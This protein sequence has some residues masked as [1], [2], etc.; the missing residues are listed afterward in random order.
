M[1]KRTSNDATGAADREIAATRIFDAPR[2]L[3]FQMWTDPKHIAQWWGPRGFT[4]TTHEMNFKP[5]G[6]WRFVMHGPDGTDYQNK[7]IYEE[8]VEPE[9]LVYSHVSGPQFHVTVNF[10][11][12]DSGKT[13]LTMR[14]LFESAAERS[15]VAKEH[16]AVEGLGQ[17]LDRLGEQLATFVGQE[18]VFTRVFDAPREL[19]WKAFVESER[20]MHWWGP[21]GF[22]MHFAKVDLRPGGIFHYGMQSPDGKDMWGKFV[23]RDVVAPERLV[24]VLSFSDPQGSTV[25]APFE[26]DWPLEILNVLTFSEQGGRTTVTLRGN[27]IN[28]TEAQRKTFEAEFKGMQQGFTGTFDQLDE[29]LATL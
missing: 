1:N 11:E 17:T 6:V 14:M 29:Y 20:L 26:L 10:E 16:G 5:G 4:T 7:I 27:P 21:K 18:F 2:E 15:R 25:Q 19:V 13:K 24:F 8:M 9:R 23:Y 28:A 12:Q 22:K 3:V